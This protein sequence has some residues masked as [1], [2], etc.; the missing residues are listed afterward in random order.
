MKTALIL[1]AAG[2][3][4]RFGTQNKLFYPIGDKPVLEWS[5]LKCLQMECKEY[6]ITVH[7]QNR[8][9]YEPILAKYPQFKEVKGGESRAKSVQNAIDHI[10]NSEYVLVHDA[11]RPYLTVSI[12]E[13]ILSELNH[14]PCVIPGLLVSDTIK[15]VRTDHI[16]HKTLD[17]FSLR[18]IQTPQGF[19][20]QSLQRAYRELYQQQIDQATDE[21]KLIED[22]GLPVKIIPGDFR[23]HK[24]TH[25]EDIEVIKPLLLPS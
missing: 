9:Q 5:I 12:I 17:R 19:Q 8:S 2:S 11:A 1:T 22:L 10:Q 25:L 16:V 7:P 15:E 14:Y 24:I 3:S 13:T 18:A 20:L 23:L 6:L 4:S 21:A